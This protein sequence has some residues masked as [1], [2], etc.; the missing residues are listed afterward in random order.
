ML[1]TAKL[2]EAQGH[3]VVPFAMQHPENFPTPYVGNFVSE[4]QTEGVRFSWQGLRTAGRMFWSF[5]ARRKLARLIQTVKPDIAHV[6]NIYGQIS[7]S[8]LSVLRKYK[9]PV[10]MTV[11]DYALLGP[12]HIPFDHGALCER[13]EKSPWEIVGHRC[14]KNSLVA[15]VWAAFVFWIHKKLKLY[16]RYIDHY[17]VPSQYLR[18]RLVKAGFLESKISYVPHFIDAAHVSSSGLGDYAACVAPLSP[19]K[20]VEVFLDAARGLSQIPIKIAGD[21]PEAARLRERVERERLRNVELVGKLVGPARDRFYRNA[22]FVVVPSLVPETFG[23]VVLEAYAAGKP[24]IASRI[25]AL[26]EVVREGKTG[27]LVPAG[28]VD[29]LRGEIKKLWED[30]DLRRAFGQYARELVEQEYHP[31]HYYDAIIQIYSKIS[32]Q[33]S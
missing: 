20:G 10:V 14:I 27:L 8:I 21:G 30:A 29:T 12:K 11:H 4:V 19:E 9:I 25:G 33:R 26:P 32:S 15:S 13:G 22:L 31:E 28:D 7:P 6:H 1:E 2:L 18:E 24:V 5:E 3:T 17:I 16:E 23:L